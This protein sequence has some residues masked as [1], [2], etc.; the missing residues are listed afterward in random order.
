[1]DP[2]SQGFFYT[3]EGLKDMATK[4]QRDAKKAASD[5][6]DAEIEKQRSWEE[7]LFND[8]VE[9]KIWYL[10][11]IK[12]P[13]WLQVHDH[14]KL[15]FRTLYR[16]VKEKNKALINFFLRDRKG[17]AFFKEIGPADNLLIKWIESKNDPVM[18]A[19]FEDYKSSMYFQTILNDALAGKIFLPREY[20]WAIQ[21]K[22]SDLSILVEKVRIEHPELK[23][24]SGQLGKDGK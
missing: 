13:R 10:D 23:G 24:H 5:Q 19:L 11:L 3:P 21:K 14:D 16:A 17:P 2:F 20:F 18:L 15:K 7:Q 4:A 1:V 22:S 6:R 9:G 8:L 12:E